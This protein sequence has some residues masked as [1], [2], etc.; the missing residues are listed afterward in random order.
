MLSVEN[1]RL[2]APDRRYRS[3]IQGPGPLLRP[4]RRHCDPAPIAIAESLECWRGSCTGPYRELL[5]PARIDA[6]CRYSKYSPGD[7]PEHVE[8]SAFSIGTSTHHRRARRRCR[9]RDGGISARSFLKTGTMW[10]LEDRKS[11][12][13]GKGVSVRVDLGCRRII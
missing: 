12:V 2:C 3:Q 4:K 1:A 6:L 5:S 10:A 8:A 7:L 9:N 11:V 13:S